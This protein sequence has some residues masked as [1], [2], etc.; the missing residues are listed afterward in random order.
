MTSMQEYVGIAKAV[1]AD[2]YLNPPV[3]YEDGYSHRGVTYPAV[4]VGD[5]AWIIQLAGVWH[6]GNAFG[7]PSTPYV[8]FRDALGAVLQST[9]GWNC[10]KP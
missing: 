9:S 7:V 10:E 2:T 6:I 1:A 3:I 4:N 5:D 8:T